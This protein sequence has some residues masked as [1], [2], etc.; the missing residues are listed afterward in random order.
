M[1]RRPNMATQ[2]NVID[3]DDGSFDREVLKATVPVLVDFVAPW[4]GPCKTLAPIV[5][6]V[7]AETAG[8]LKV[9]KIDTEASPRTAE[10]Y[11]IRGVPMLLVFRNGEK[12]AGHLGVTTREKLL[13]LLE[14]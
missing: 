3:V 2:T 10:R 11:G 14:P 4:C 13:E 8:R 7:A 12:T 6:R 1:G 9:V 5:E